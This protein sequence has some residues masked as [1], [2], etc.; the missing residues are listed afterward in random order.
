MNINCLD[1]NM[2]KMVLIEINSATYL[3]DYLKKI[4]AQEVRICLKLRNIL[5]FICSFGISSVYHIFV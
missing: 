4:I 5:L 1:D 2:D 3:K